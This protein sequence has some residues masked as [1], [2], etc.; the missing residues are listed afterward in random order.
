MPYLVPDA[1]KWMKKAYRSFYLRPRFI[2]RKVL[3]LK[4]IN[5]LKKYV[6]G[7]WGLVWFS[8]TPDQETND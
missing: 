6:R 5:A 3:Q 8:M 7:A 4:S 2:L 1:E